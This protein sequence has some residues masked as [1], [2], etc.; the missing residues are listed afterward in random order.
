MW[1][2]INRIPLDRPVIVKSVTGIVCR[3]RVRYREDRG[4]TPLQVFC[5]RE[6]TGKR[7]RIVRWR[8]DPFAYAT[9]GSDQWRS[10]V[11]IPKDR[12]VI[13]ETSEGKTCWARYLTHKPRAVTCSRTHGGGTVAAVA[14]H[15]DPTLDL[16]PRRAPRRG[17][18][19]QVRHTPR[20][21]WRSVARI[22]LDRAVVVK[23]V[24]GFVCRAW[25][26]N[27]RRREVV[28]TSRWGP[29]R[30]ACIRDDPR[31]TE[32]MAVAWREDTG[33]PIR[34]WIRRPST[35]KD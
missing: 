19:P 6:D 24:T 35:E 34:Q 17:A 11:S 31:R 3:A 18:K 14:W 15:E 29:R 16:S 9:Y 25:T 22:P 1:R 5:T 33:A 23:T 30:V 8:N 26:A 2:S 27:P 21:Y 4:G 10:P 13:V 7:V 20:K 12:R 28:P 32:V